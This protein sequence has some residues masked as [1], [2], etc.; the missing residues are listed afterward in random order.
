MGHWKDGATRP[1]IRH[2]PRHV[3]KRAEEAVEFMMEANCLYE[4]S[5][6]EF[7]EAMADRFGASWLT[8]DGKPDRRLV[9]DV[10]TL[11]REQEGD[12]TAY[13]ICQGYVV[14]YSGPK[15]G[16]VMYGDDGEI[17]L[18]HLLLTLN[19]DALRQQCHKTENRRRGTIWSTAARAC[20]NDG[21]HD[22]GLLLSQMEHEI[23]RTGFVS[24]GLVQ[25][26]QSALKQ[27]GLV[28]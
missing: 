16:M 19:G 10:C 6:Q 12:P 1:K 8:R 21:D 23:D 9:E 26:F 3:Y 13:A 11:T 17:P 18:M 28:A 20:L 4:G 5:K 24:D 7:A 25:E 2:V 15:G 22:L 14:A 27:R